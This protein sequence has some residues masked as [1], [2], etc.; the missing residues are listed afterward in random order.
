MYNALSNSEL[1]GCRN[2]ARGERD[3]QK[4]MGQ[5]PQVDVPPSLGALA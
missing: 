3:T 1:S 4:R 5:W 2:E